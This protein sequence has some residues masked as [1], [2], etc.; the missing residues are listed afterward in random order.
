MAQSRR[1]AKGRGTTKS[2]LKKKK[3]VTE[4]KKR[5]KRRSDRPSDRHVWAVDEAAVLERQRRP[6]VPR[7]DVVIAPASFAVPKAPEDAK[8]LFDVDLTEDARPP[9]P[10]PVQKKPTFDTLN[11]DPLLIAPPTLLIA[12]PTI[13]SI[14]PPIDDDLEGVCSV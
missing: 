14:V 5:V 8:W 9:R 10:R 6:E 4:R 7:S 12:P 11:D 2:I 1:A 3:K 13:P